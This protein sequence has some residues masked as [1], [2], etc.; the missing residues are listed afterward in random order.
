M[1]RDLC[2]PSSEDVPCPFLWQM[3]V[4]YNGVL[5]GLQSSNDF[6]KNTMIQL[7]CPKDVAE[8]YQGTAET[9]EPANGSIS[10]EQA[11][12]SLNLYTT[13]LHGINSAIIKLGKLTKATKVRQ[14]PP[15]LALHLHDSHLPPHLLVHAHLCVAY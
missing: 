11:K 14:C 15:P 7:C 8:Q 1:S 6:L 5:R 4:K 2:D 13:T 9:F 12:S 3:F 10:F